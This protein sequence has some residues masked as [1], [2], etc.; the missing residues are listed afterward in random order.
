VHADFDAAVKERRLSQKRQR[1]GVLVLEHCPTLFNV[2]SFVG[3]SLLVFLCV[4]VKNNVGH[5]YDL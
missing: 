1:L 4:W 2:A 5:A 3:F